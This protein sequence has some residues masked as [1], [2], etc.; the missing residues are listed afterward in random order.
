MYRILTAFGTRA[1]AIKFAPLIRELRRRSGRFELS[2]VVTGEHRASLQQVLTLF[3]I[4]PDVDLNIGRDE[5]TCLI[6]RTKLLARASAGLGEALTKFNP[7]LVVVLG[8]TL[9]TLAATLAAYYRQIPTAHVEAGLRTEDKFGTFPEEG[10]RKMV[11]SIAD[12]HFAPTETARGHLLAEG[13]EAD[14]IFVTGNTSI[15][16]LRWVRDITESARPGREV[17]LQDLFPPEI[18][19]P[20]LLTRLRE[21][22]RG[23]RR[24][25]LITSNRPETFGARL[26]T[27]CGAVSR[28]TD[29]FP[30]AVFV[31][32]V[33]L[34]QKVKHNVHRMLEDIPNVYVLPP[35]NYQGFVYLMQ[36]SHFVMTD[37]GTIQ[38]EAPG[39]DKPV[40]VMRNVTDRPEAL[41]AG[42]IA[43]VGSD[44]VRIV[45][46]AR[47]LMGD[48][49]FHAKM[50]SAPNPFGD[51]NAA[52]RIVDALEAWSGQG[53]DIAK[54]A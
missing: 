4:E 36:L 10:H 19:P 40:L 6:D 47:R 7:D 32:P 43:L 2:V 41:E 22:E 51:G 54:S 37:S 42:T 21:V 46:G 24:L 35:V 39:L 1:E 11:S 9:T 23:E 3:E 25:V 33:D 50:C 13:I 27:I 49:A 26:Q 31:Y 28:L 15:D 44:A 48:T 14:T 45:T 30:E 18:A 16:A 8:D 34:E 29:E 53:T 5:E 20:K 38:E 17:K 12:L 52:K